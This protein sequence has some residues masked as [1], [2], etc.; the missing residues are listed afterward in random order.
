MGAVYL[1]VLLKRLPQDAAGESID[2]LIDTGA[3]YSVARGR[4]WIGWASCRIGRSTSC[5]PTAAG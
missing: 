5:L 1:D 3:T 4:C 2:F